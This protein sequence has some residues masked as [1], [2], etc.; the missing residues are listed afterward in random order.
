MAALGKDIFILAA[1][2]TPIAAFRA[3][4]GGMSAPALGATAIRGALARAAVR[5]EDVEDVVMGNVI[6]AGAGQSP[7]RQAS[8]GAGIPTSAEATTINKVCASGMKAVSLAAQSILAGQSQLVVA[9]GMESMSNVPYYTPRDSLSY[10]HVQT[11]DGILADG[12]WD[13]VNNF[14]MGNCAENTA[15]KHNITREQQDEYAIRSFTRSQKSLAEGLFTPEITP[16]EIP[17][18]RASDKP[19]VFSVD[20]GPGKAKFDRIPTLRPAF[21]ADGTITAA[22]ASTLNDGAAALVLASAEYVQAHG[23]KPIGRIVSFADGARDHIDFP[24]APA[25]SLPRAI[26]AAQLTTRDISL[27]EINE[28]FAVVPLVNQ[29]LLDLDP[30]TVNVRGGAI[31]LGHPIGAS[32]ARILVTLLH[33]LQAGQFG[34]ASICN[35]GGGSSSMVVQR[36]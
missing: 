3:A 21:E 13:A 29:Q 12:L 4:L 24:T 35:G 36:L 32:G 16:V 26:A 30:E 8:F 5:P 20:E 23:L 7:A 10:G 15:R 25:I 34:A 9:G 17:G 2:R 1:T 18:R 31:S 28:A 6:S 22:N 33:A 19:T 27:Y 11:R 14:H